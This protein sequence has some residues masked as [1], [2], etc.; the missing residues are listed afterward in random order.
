MLRRHVSLAEQIDDAAR[1][2][3]NSCECLIGVATNRLD[4]TDRDFPERT[5]TIATPYLLQETAMAFQIE[6][7]FLIF[8]AVEIT[9]QAVTNRNLWIEIEPELGKSGRIHRMAFRRSCRQLCG[10][11]GYRCVASPRLFW[12]FLPQRSGV[13]TVQ[14]PRLV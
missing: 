1:R 11:G 4:A 10:F 5:P 14:L 9:L 7:P 8:K 6:L 3:M 2:L 12:G 13:Q